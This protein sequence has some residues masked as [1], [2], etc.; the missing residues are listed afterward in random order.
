M[1]RSVPLVTAL[2]AAACMATLAA[3]SS[4]AAKPPTIDQSLETFSVSSPQISPDGKR[5]IYEQGRTNWETNAFDTELWIA[6]VG[7]GSQRL[8]SQRGSSSSDAAWSSDGKWIGFL[9]D[10]PGSLKDSPA[11]KRQLYIMPSDGGEAQQISKME[12]GVN[13]FEWSPDSKH[14]AIAAQGPEPKA[15][16]DR[17]ESFGDY[18]VIHG[19]YQ[20]AHLWMVSVPVADEAGRIPKPEEPRLLTK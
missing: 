13:S 11:G 5:V 8:L 2:V 17:K 18:K 1:L 10:R 9:S 7:S 6:D 4:A 20:M 12:E 15:M 16:K 19:D 14:I 3:Q